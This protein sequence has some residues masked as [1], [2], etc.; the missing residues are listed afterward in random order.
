MISSIF[1]KNYKQFDEL[2]LN[3]LKRVN[4]IAGSN[5][6]GKTS[7]L[8]GIFTFFDRGA[9]DVTLRQF[10]WRGVQTVSLSPSSVWQP[11][12]HN[13]D[14]SL[15]ISIEVQDDGI[16]QRLEYSHLNDFS[17]T[18]TSS[19]NQG[20]MKSSYTSQVRTESLKGAYFENGKASGETYLYINDGQV[21]LDLRG[22]NRPNKLATFV[23]SSTKSMM[24]QDAENLGVIDVNEGLEHITEALRVIEPRL[25]SLTIIP[26]AQQSYVYG[27]IGIG[28]KLPIAFMGE[29]ISKLLSILVTIATTPNGVV[30]IDELEN[31]IHYSLF[32][33]VI[34]NIIAMAE[35]YDSQ[36]FITTHSHDLL[37]GMSEY[38]S[39]TA[40]DNITFIRLD[41]VNDK[42][43][44]KHYSSSMLSTAVD[45]NWELR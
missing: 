29:G 39:E 10:S 31:G 30:I 14:L 6:V 19:H 33:K 3:D 28:K 36:V 42:I 18:L 40:Q 11:I 13:Y 12:F 45:R 21:S 35:R 23:F 1:L 7:V 37:K 26:H 5:N 2:S 41:R 27:D 16:T 8:E 22:F 25:K 15:P 20:G 43:V 17:T 44:P 9:P 38:Y 24:N 4:V 32:T 34:K